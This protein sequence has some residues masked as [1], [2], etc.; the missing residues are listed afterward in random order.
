MSAVGLDYASV[1]P[2]L[3][4]P[5]S[6]STPNSRGSTGTTTSSSMRPSSVSAQTSTSVTTSHS[7]QSNSNNTTASSIDSAP[8]DAQGVLPLTALLRRPDLQ[9]QST[10]PVPPRSP[11]RH[12]RRALSAPR[13]TKVKETLDARVTKREDGQRMLNQYVLQKE[14]GRGAYGTVLQAV[15]STTGKEYAIKE[16]SKARLRKRNHSAILRRP[17]GALGGPYGAQG[18]SGGGGRGGRPSLLSRRSATDIHK[19]EEAGN[20]L[21]LIRSELAIMKKLDHENVIDLL[22]VLDDPE[23]DALYMVLELCKKGVIMQIGFGA[24]A[25]A[26]SDEECRH[27]FRDLILGIEYLH[28]QGIAHRDIKPDNLLLSSDSVLKIADFGVS[29][30]FQLDDDQK[31]AQSG[32]PAFMSPE[33]CHGA[34]N[35]SYLKASDIWSMG[36]TLFC[37]KFG[38]LPFGETNLIELCADIMNRP[39]ILLDPEFPGNKRHI[40]DDNLLDLFDKILAKDPEQRIT[41]DALREHPWVTCDGEDELLSAEENTAQ[42]IQE[43]TEDDLRE[44]IKGIRGAVTVVKAVFKLK[45]MREAKSREGS[46]ERQRRESAAA[47]DREDAEKQATADD[48]AQSLERTRLAE[49]EHS[50]RKA[51]VEERGRTG[52]QAASETNLPQSSGSGD[53]AAKTT[54][55]RELPR[56]TIVKRSRSMDAASARLNG[57]EDRI[58]WNAMLGIEPGREQHHGVSET[59]GFD[60]HI[61]DLTKIQRACV[62]TMPSASDATD[63]EKA[64]SNGLARSRTQLTKQRG[65]GPSNNETGGR[66][67]RADSL[68]GGS[69]KENQLWQRAGDAHRGTPDLGAIAEKASAAQQDR[70]RHQSLAAP[71]GQAAARF[72]A[73]MGNTGSLGSLAA[74]L[75]QQSVNQAVHTVPPILNVGG[76]LDYKAMSA[77]QPAASMTII[78]ES[79]ST[80]RTNI[81]LQGELREAYEANLAKQQL[82]LAEQDESR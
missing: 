54:Y 67:Q 7:L 44:A 82:K 66:A 42:M 21:F 60:A 25:E 29:E 23:G 64:K 58:L 35:T 4:R 80:E 77:D 34:R 55:P 18:P 47:Q 76:G 73:A 16:F 8:K 78:A 51:A 40:C 6:L 59:D 5:S 20:P 72:K 70:P 62:T 17:R 37:W 3:M 36:V 19:D 69:A 56:P 22:E 79:P 81:S 65:K 12:H 68:Q 14:I 48:L 9:R 27:Y 53:A 38:T 11:E 75:A 26:F 46:P 33:L 13:A 24:N 28:A 52:L 10:S 15:D 61:A 32:S 1:A 45:Q 57:T 31:V 74:P 2:A 30:L 50:K 71:S 41:M 63:K 39:P 43:I 49:E